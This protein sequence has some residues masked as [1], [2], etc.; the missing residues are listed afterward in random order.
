MSGSPSKSVAVILNV[1]DSPTVKFTVFPGGLDESIV[2]GLF[3]ITVSAQRWTAHAPRTSLTLTSMV[4]SPTSRNAANPPLWKLLP[5]VLFSVRSLPEASNNLHAYV[6]C[7]SGPSGS[8]AVTLKDIAAPAVKS[9]GGGF[10]GGCGKLMTGTAFVPLSTM[11][12]HSRNTLPTLLAMTTFMIFSPIRGM[13]RSSED[14]AL[15][16]VGTSF[17]LKNHVKVKGSP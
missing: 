12:C 3:R 6:S 17:P 14:E 10:P 16:M 11:M 7:S 8:V 4:Y 5:L 1:C 9:K 15:F 13:T 2:G